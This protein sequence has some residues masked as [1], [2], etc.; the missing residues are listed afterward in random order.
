[1]KK[2]GGIEPTVFMKHSAALFRREDVNQFDR[3]VERSN[4]IDSST[5]CPPETDQHQDQQREHCEPEEILF[6]IGLVNRGA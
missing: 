1:M 3:P 4:T 5:I 2:T 6:P